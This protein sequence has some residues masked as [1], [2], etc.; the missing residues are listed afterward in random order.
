LLFFMSPPESP[1]GASSAWAIVQ[2]VGS[3]TAKNRKH[4]RII[5]M[6]IL[7]LRSAR[8]WAPAYHTPDPP[9]R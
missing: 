7:L 3:I 2:E 6:L 1:A 4:A 5:F 8:E 9:L